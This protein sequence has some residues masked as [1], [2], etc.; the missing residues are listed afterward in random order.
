MKR[1][2]FS[3]PARPWRTALLIAPAAATFASAAHAQ[4][5]ISSSRTVAGGNPF[6]ESVANNVNIGRAPGNVDVAGVTVDVVGAGS[7][8]GFSGFLTNLYSSSAVNVLGG[9]VGRLSLFGNNSVTV[10]GGNLVGYSSS[11]NSGVTSFQVSGGTVSQAPGAGNQLYYG[12]TSAFSGG[13][14][15]GTTAIIG[16]NLTVSGAAVSTVSL[17]TGTITQTAGATRYI[18]VDRSSGDDSVAA[19]ITIRGGTVG[20]NAQKGGISTNTFQSNATPTNVSILGGSV[21][22][23]ILSR[24]TSAASSFQIRGGT[25]SDYGLN[26]SQQVNLDQRASFYILGATNFDFYGTNLALS[27]PIAGVFFSTLGSEIGEGNILY[28][29]SYYTITGTLENG[30][31]INNRIFDAS[32]G[33]GAIRLNAVG[34]ANGANAPEP[35]SLA[36]L[37]PALGI[38]GIAIRRR[39]G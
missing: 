35:G 28:S 21:S 7:L 36:L 37:L 10:S 22:E 16:G 17:K 33:T 14:V 8:N 27:A 30:Q 29:G 11:F 13:A 38:A 12:N 3:S 5:F 2:L 24:G 9:N 31:T 1:P 19:N 34:P 6:S 4:V 18:E 32:S 15:G 26:G 20:V 23:G 25:F 39:K